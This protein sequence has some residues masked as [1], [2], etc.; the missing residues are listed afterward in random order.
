[1]MYRLPIGSSGRGAAVALA[2]GLAA[3]SMHPLPEDVSPASTYDIVARMRCEVA[4]GLKDFP[5]NEK[6]KKI[7]NATHIGYDFTFII[8]ED[9]KALNGRLEFKRP[10]FVDDKGFFLDL[11]ASA[12]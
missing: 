8:S 11:S 2:F 12:V 6:Y 5:R 3:C 4:E 10:S 7:V 9:N 1:M